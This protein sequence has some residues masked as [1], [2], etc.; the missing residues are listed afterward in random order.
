MVHRCKLWRE[1][2][3]SALATLSVSV[4]G[5]ESGG[6]VGLAK[7]HVMPS[8]TSQDSSALNADSEVQLSTAVGVPGA[9]T[10]QWQQRFPETGSKRRAL[11]TVDDQLQEQLA[12]IKSDYVAVRIEAIQNLG[13]WQLEKNSERAADVFQILIDHRRQDFNDYEDVYTDAALQQMGEI[14]VAEV[15]R[16]E[17]SSELPELSNACEGMRSLGEAFYPQLRETLQTMLQ[18]ESPARNWGAMYVLEK[19]GPSGADSLPLVAKYLNDDDFQNQ[20]IA[21]RAMA[22]MGP[23]AATQWETVR[24]LTESGQNISVVSHS[25]RTL[26]YI[27]VGDPALGKRAAETI[28]E[29]LGDFAFMSKSRALEGLIALREDAAPAGEKARELMSD[30]TGLAPQAAVVYAYT[31]GDWGPSMK[32][33]AS[34]V[35]DL[36][37]GL[38]VLALLKQVGPHGR[39]TADVLIELA[40]DSDEVV[41]LAA[42]QALVA[43]VTLSSPD[44]LKQLSAEDKQY[45]EK[46]TPVLRQLME[47]GEAEPHHFAR[48]TLARWKEWGW[49][50][51]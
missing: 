22:A 23:A 50:V 43:Q 44:D 40:K 42:A 18:A 4:T 27:S 47:S 24:E 46:L 13:R 9:E 33:L 49:E 30:H 26:G 41:A 29:H 1:L 48:T 25:L 37:V 12:A 34:Q 39:S 20:I 36:S 28:K 14:A 15:L 10:D 31:S 5:C 21:L 7:T 3:V 51:P 6:E 11:Q 16:L 8:S 2:F 32:L 35:S 17:K 45:L 38:E 19:M